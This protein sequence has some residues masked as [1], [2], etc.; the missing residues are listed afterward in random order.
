[1]NY[2]YWLDLASF[3]NTLIDGIERI[4]WEYLTVL[5]KKGTIVEIGSNNM[6]EIYRKILKECEE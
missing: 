6:N 1:M 3:Y 2:E 5:I 4:I